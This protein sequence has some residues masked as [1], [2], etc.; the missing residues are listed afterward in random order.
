MGK[1]FY[2]IMLFSI[3]F[4]TTNIVAQYKISR[5]DSLKNK[6]TTQSTKL[7]ADETERAYFS[8]YVILG[9]VIKIVDTPAPLSEMFHSDVIIQVDSVLKGTFA[10]KQIIIKQQS[11][12]ITDGGPKKKHQTVSMDNDFY[13]GE[14]VVLFIAPKENLSFFNSPYVNKY[15]KSFSGKKSVSALSNDAFWVSHRQVAHIRSGDIYYNN[16][17]YNL[18]EFINNITKVN[19]NK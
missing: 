10:K 3:L 7:I 1:V 8:D 2:H 18:S 6:S 4:L 13:I 5:A 14:Q 12:S 11:G 17:P 15:Y 9:K 19:S 16:T